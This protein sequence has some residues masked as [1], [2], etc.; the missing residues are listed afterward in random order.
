METMLRPAWIAIDAPIS[1]DIHFAQGSLA[2][3]D[4]LKPGAGWLR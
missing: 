1:A 2:G 3:S 4:A